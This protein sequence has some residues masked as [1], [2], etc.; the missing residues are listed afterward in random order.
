MNLFPAVN[1]IDEL[2]AEQQSLTA[3]ERFQEK[4]HPK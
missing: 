3:V 1:L 4:I 2:L